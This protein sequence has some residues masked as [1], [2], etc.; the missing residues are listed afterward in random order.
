LFVSYF[1]LASLGNV[2]I[3]VREEMVAALLR[4]MVEL[5]SFALPTDPDKFGRMFEA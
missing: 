3:V 2:L 1:R 5:G 4:L